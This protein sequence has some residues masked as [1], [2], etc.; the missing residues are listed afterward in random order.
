MTE[1][2]QDRL[3]DLLFEDEPECDCDKCVK[4]ADALWELQD[5][6]ER[7]ESSVAV[8]IRRTGPFRW[9]FTV[10]RADGWQIE[11]PATFGYRSCCAEAM[12]AIQVLTGAS[13]A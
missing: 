9:Q 1:D 8:R 3:V 4:I 12:E 10:T 13:H 7:F 11:G 2:L 6:Q 5:R